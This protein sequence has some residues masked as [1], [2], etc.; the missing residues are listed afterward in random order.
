MRALVVALIMFPLVALSQE[1][2]STLSSNLAKGKFSAHARTFFMATANEGD[3]TD[4]HAWAIGAGIG[5]ESPEIRHF[6]IGISGFFIFNLA[7]SDLSTPD[8]LTNTLNRYEIG[9][10]DITDP[11]NHRDLDRLEELFL[12]YRI[13]KSFF[14]I[15]KVILNTP[16][17][18]PQ[19]GRMRP[20]LEQGFVFEVNEIRNIKI[21]GAYIDKISPRSTVRWY[22]V[23]Q[24]IGIYP[25]GLQATGAR[26]DY[27]GHVE[28][29][30][31]FLLGVNYKQQTAISFWN[32]FIENVSNTAFVQVEREFLDK[33]FYAGV[34][35]VR[36]DVAGE[37]GNADEAQAYMPR[38]AYSNIFSSR[39][40]H[41]KNNLDL[42]VNATAIQS[43]S[44]YLMPREWG[45]DPF[46][47]FLPRERVEGVGK[48]KAVSL[49]INYAFPK[50]HIRSSLGV[51]YYHMPDVRD[52][53]YNKYAMPSFSQ[54]NAEIRY[55][56]SKYFEGASIQFLYTYKLGTG[57]DYEN[58]KNVINKVN[59]GNVSLV[60]NYRFENYHSLGKKQGKQ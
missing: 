25:Q 43:N 4:Y 58:P 28:S 36:Q 12:Q 42:N 38:D 32:T 16:F 53:R 23:G 50:Q 54:V 24:S 56:F 30:G 7:S 10:F 40:G 1:G 11:D 20:T 49:N 22:S 3:L 18:N 13:H 26:S 5:Y 57:E 52:Y 39:F 34:Q 46:Y 48:L 41:K 9:L 44:R 17:I 31:I 33:R 29:N 51:G 21:E 59:M 2:D 8:P 35:Y 27:A 60:F 15:G 14:R 37:G 55:D 19:D 6:K 45:R 47:T